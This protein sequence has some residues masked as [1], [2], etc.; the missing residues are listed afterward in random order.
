[1]NSLS[2]FLYI[3]DVVSNISVF[4]S[5]IGVICVCLGALSIIP[6]YFV[7][8]EFEDS[9][10]TIKK[11]RQNLAWFAS[12]SVIFGLSAIFISTLVPAKKTM[13]MIAASEMGEMVVQS[14]EAKEIFSELKQTIMYQLR[15]L[16]HTKKE[17]NNE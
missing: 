5:T 17:N 14:E 3:A 16:R 8:W 10:E 11:N 12:R 4:L 7:K 1:M 9:N 6:G 13:Y 15:D 2:W